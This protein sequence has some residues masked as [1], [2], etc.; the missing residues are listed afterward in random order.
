[1]T[2]ETISMII[3][4]NM[5]IITTLWMWEQSGWN[6]CLFIDCQGFCVMWL[7]G[8][9]LPPWFLSVISPNQPD[10]WPCYPDSHF[11]SL[12]PRNQSQR[13]RSSGW[14]LKCLYTVMKALLILSTAR[15]LRR[16]S[17]LC[18]RTDTQGWAGSSRHKGFR[19]WREM[20][21]SW[22]CL[23]AKPHA[24]VGGCIC[25]FL[26]YTKVSCGLVWAPSH[27]LT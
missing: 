25:L 11:P 14:D 10:L 26:I 2:S 1:M 19:Q 16:N 6:I 21:K 23:L 8:P 24:V 18:S 22:L 15:S 17:V 7:A 12:N 5:K 9:A 27:N 20:V 3:C 13:C 4:K